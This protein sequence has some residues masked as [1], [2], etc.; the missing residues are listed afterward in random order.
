MGKRDRGH[1][2]GVRGEGERNGRGKRLGAAFWGLEGPTAGPRAYSRF[3]GF[4][5]RLAPMKNQ[6]A[7]PG[8]GKLLAIGDMHLGSRPSGVPLNLPGLDHSDLS[9]AAALAS[10]V[11]VGIECNVDA[12]LFA[13]DLVENTNARFE[14]MRP[15]ESAVAEL[16]AVGISTWAVGGNHDA[17]ALPRLRAT[18]PK[19]RLLGCNGQWESSVLTSQGREFAELVGWSFPARQHSLSPVAGLLKSPM[20]DRN[21]GLPR[22]GLLHGDLNG[23][24]TYAPF[25]LSELEQTDFDTWLLGHIHKP[26]FGKEAI[27]GQAPFGYLGSLVG[28]D[29][30]EPGDRGP[31]LIEISEDGSVQYEQKV[32]APLRWQEITL[33]I[34]DSAQPD[35]VADLI[36]AQ[37]AQAADA[38]H[39]RGIVPRAL[40]LRFTLVGRPLHGRGIR[41]LVEDETDWSELQPNQAGTEIFINRVR[42]RFEP[43][44]DLEALAKGNDPVGLLARDLLILAGPRCSEREELLTSA[45]LALSEEAQHT[46]WK[47]V[48]ATRHYSDPTQESSLVRHLERAGRQAL[49][50]L[51][52][53]AAVDEQP[54]VGQEVRQ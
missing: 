22:V 49:G 43:H 48:R 6:T 53:Q 17:E 45:R 2:N 19:L 10:A 52:A 13:G 23:T 30:G 44:Q 21:T 20:A 3:P 8:G 33:E 15:L 11:Q 1:G 29:A 37:A 50:A 31:W 51:L 9:P 14:A 54:D 7:M 47:E 39:L 41:R 24:G 27:N 36:T 34:E 26:S 35:D 46:R 40:G 25:K 28:L 16:N 42:T 32:I 38:L 5:V 12:V 4:R 18:I